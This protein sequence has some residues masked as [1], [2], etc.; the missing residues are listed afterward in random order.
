M[1]KEEHKRALAII[2]MGLFAAIVSI[3]IIAFLVAYA[4]T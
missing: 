2:E 1:K 4:Q 3:G